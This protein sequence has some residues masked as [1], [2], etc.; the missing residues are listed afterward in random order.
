MISRPVRDSVLKI[1]DGNSWF[2][3][4]SYELPNNMLFAKLIVLGCAYSCGVDPKS[5]QEAVGFPHNSHATTTHI[6]LSYRYCSSHDSQMV[7]ITNEVL[8][9]PPLQTE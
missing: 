7:K 5:N 6:D 2:T 8:Q 9:P 4:G 1:K 3:P